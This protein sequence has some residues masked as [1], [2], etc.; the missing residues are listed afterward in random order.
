MVVASEEA[1]VKDNQENKENTIP[2]EN[3]WVQILANSVSC[4]SA[5]TVGLLFAWTSPFIVKILDDETYDVTD[6]QASY[7]T[8][9]PPIAMILSSL[10][11]SKLCDLIGRKRTLMLIT[12]PHVLAWLLTLS[13]NI[14]LLYVSRF[15]AGTGDGCLFAVLP[16]YIG[17]ISTPRVRCIY[18]N[19]VNVFTYFGMFLVNVIGSQTSVRTTAFI[20]LPLPLIFLVSMHFMPESPSWHVMK[21]KEEEA[22]AC[23]RRLRCKEDVEAIYRQLE[24]DVTRQMSETGTWKD[25]VMNSTNRKALIAGVFL[26]V[27]QLIG[28]VT[29]FNVYTQYIFKHSGTD[30]SSEIASMIYTGMCFVLIFLA[31]FVVEKIGRRKAFMFS[32]LFCGVVLILEGVYFYV[33]QQRHDV[34]LSKVKW[35]PVAGMLLYIVFCSSG[36]IL[37]PTLMLGE[38]FSA[39]IK[40]KGLSV[41]VITF[42]LMIF[43]SNNIFYWL[44]SGVGMWGPF[45][46]FGVSNLV[47]TFL[48]VLFVPETKGKTLEEIQQSLKKSRPV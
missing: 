30:V 29:V 20:C 41:L 24:A 32:I 12:I 21:G 5:I 38:L 19:L 34:D 27:S 25:L 17:E 26:R 39:S 9:I 43:V 48:T 31:G 2:K 6:N 37:I 47:S 8:V 45:V 11:F 35:L 7:L 18:G 23:L 15:F 10:A 40:A 46:F 4:L 1:G 28:G 33:D 36:I 42:G 3:I 14:N 44:K 16:M 22:K 13:K